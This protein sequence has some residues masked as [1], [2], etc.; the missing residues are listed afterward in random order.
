MIYEKNHTPLKI[1]EGLFIGDYLTAQDLDYLTLNKVTRIINCCS[2]QIPNHWEQ[3]GFKYY[4]LPWLECQNNFIINIQD[5]YNFIDQALKNGES[6][7][8]HSVRGQQRTTIVISI[9]LMKGFRWT[10]NKCLE[11]LKSLTSI[12]LKSNIVLQLNRFERQIKPISKNWNQ[13]NDLNMEL[14]VR[15]TYINSLKY[16]HPVDWKSKGQK[17]V[18]WNK[19]LITME[20]PPYD[21]IVF[22]TKSR[23]LFFIRNHQPV[24]DRP[25]TATDR[26]KTAPLN[27]HRKMR[28]RSPL[29]QPKKLTLK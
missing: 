8:V 23:P 7:L 21:K 22:K 15:N 2:Q 25:K 20:I 10:L 28:F 26:P 19:N 18:Q 24:T 5:C 16:L 17:Q 1:I 9:Y 6:V 14:M 12:Q 29:V 13:V 11:Y 3:L 4:S 27:N